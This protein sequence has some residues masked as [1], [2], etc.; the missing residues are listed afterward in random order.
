MDLRMQDLLST[1]GM[2]AKIA[3]GDKL[4]VKSKYIGIDQRWFQSIRRTM[5]GESR[6]ATINRLVEIYREVQEKIQIMT[7]NVENCKKDGGRN[8][9]DSYKI[10]RS[11]A[12]SLA[13]SNDGIK[14]LISTY[15]IDSSLTS[16][17]ESIREIYI[18]GIYSDLYDLLPKEY[19]P[20]TYTFGDKELL[21]GVGVQ[22]KNNIEEA[23]D[24]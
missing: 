19:K 21:G 7:E 15:D 17:L 2:L 6:D 5:D 20:N 13:K 4:I 3:P 9:N 11:T 18:K 16:R 23:L 14:S 24:F 1:L 8:L 12:N 10:L 22:E